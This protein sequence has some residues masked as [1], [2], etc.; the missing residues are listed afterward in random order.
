[1]SEQEPKSQRKIPIFILVQIVI[2]ILAGILSYILQDGMFYIVSVLLSL[3]I[4]LLANDSK[5]QKSPNAEMKIEFDAC[6]TPHGLEFEIAVFKIYGLDTISMLK[7]TKLILADFGFEKFE[8]DSTYTRYGTDILIHSK[9]NEFAG[10]AIRLLLWL[11]Q[12]KPFIV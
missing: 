6:E 11:K 4:P 10:N 3:F 1:M 2:W 7:R 9:N 8:E 12:L 5:K